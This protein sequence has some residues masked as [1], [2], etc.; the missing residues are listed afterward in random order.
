MDD[1]ALVAPLWRAE[2]FELRSYNDRFISFGVIMLQISEMGALR[3]LAC[4]ATNTEAGEI[5][6]GTDRRERGG[7]KPPPPKTPTVGTILGYNPR[8]RRWLTG[9]NPDCQSGGLLTGVI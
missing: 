1:D 7:A 6:S 9:N 3:Q 5:R 2:R 4:Y 8:Q